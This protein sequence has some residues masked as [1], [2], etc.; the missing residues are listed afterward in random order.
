MKLDGMNQWRTCTTYIVDESKKEIKRAVNGK[1]HMDHGDKIVEKEQ[2][3]VD[4]NNSISEKFIC[5]EFTKKKKK[6]TQNNKKCW[7]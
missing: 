5:K 1:K 6:K 7:P 3:S 4:L 2:C